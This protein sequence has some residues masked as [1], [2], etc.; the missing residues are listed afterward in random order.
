MLI[1]EEKRAHRLCMSFVYENQVH[2]ALS[3]IGQ[4]ARLDVVKEAMLTFSTMVE[5]QDENFLGQESFAQSLM[6]FLRKISY[7]VDPTLLNEFVELL[8]NISAKI[9]QTPDILPVW[10]TSPGSER[11][12]DNL[13]QQMQFAGV[14]NK[15]DFPLFYLLI[16][17][18][19]RE[20]RV[21]DFA[22]TG[23][24]YIIEAAI[25]G[26]ELERWMLESDLATLMASGVGALYSQLGRLVTFHRL[27][28]IGESLS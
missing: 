24:L 3:K 21:G 14:T 5:S 18:V 27:F 8:F 7:K 17:F 11:E 4:S 22:R 25:P 20:G 9:R 1:E 23:L 16:Q 26:S 6:D 12:Y 15:E 13:P 2:I 28:L 10:F 19:Y